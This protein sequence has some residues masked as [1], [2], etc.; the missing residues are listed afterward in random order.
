LVA[1]IT[2]GG[3]VLGEVAVLDVE[4]V[5]AEVVVLG[6]DVVFD[7]V[8][9]LDAEVVLDAVVEV[10]ARPPVPHAAR[11]TATIPMLAVTMTSRVAIDT[12]RATRRGRCGVEVTIHSVSSPPPPVIGRGGAFAAATRSVYEVHGYARRGTRRI[13]AEQ[14]IRQV[15]NGKE[16]PLGR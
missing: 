6:A 2:V 5:L 13:G 15:R 3:G 14:D 12:W 8:V 4:L 1:F 7:V 16:P 10:R 11:I 9:V